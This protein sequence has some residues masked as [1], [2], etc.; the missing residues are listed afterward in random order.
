MVIKA[1]P[2]MAAAPDLEVIRPLIEES[3]VKHDEQLELERIKSEEQKAQQ[4]KL[5]AETKIRHEQET[6]T[7]ALSDARTK[8]VSRKRNTRKAFV[9]VITLALVFGAHRVMNGETGEYTSLYSSD[10]KQIMK[11]LSDQGISCYWGAN[12]TEYQSTSCDAY[13]L[14]LRIDLSNEDKVNVCETGISTFNSVSL[15]GENW[16]L[17]PWSVVDR[18]DFKKF[19]RALGGK[20]QSPASWCKAPGH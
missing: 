20:I 16:M 10:Y 8:Q 19:Q 13:N 2:E 7:Q 1:H 17:D 12:L 3:R 14:S 15:F 11:S 9:L 4:A 5:S 6:R 18:N